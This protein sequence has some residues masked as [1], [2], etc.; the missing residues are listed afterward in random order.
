MLPVA[1]AFGPTDPSTALL[2]IVAVAC[3]ASPHSS[4]RL[5]PAF[6]AVRWDSLP[7]AWPSGCS[8]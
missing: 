2:Y 5:R 1:A 7:W 3:F 6:R 8:Q 4:R